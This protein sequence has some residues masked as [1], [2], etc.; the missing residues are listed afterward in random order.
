MI[1][2]MWVFISIYLSFLSITVDDSPVTV[3]PELWVVSAT[4]SS[5]PAATVWCAGCCATVS[6]VWAAAG[7][8]AS[9]ASG[10]AAAA[11]ATARS[12]AGWSAAPFA[13][14]S[15]AARPGSAA[16]ASAGWSA[17]SAAALSAVGRS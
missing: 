14:R 13:G 17:T 15:A 16:A 3:S 10:R 4:A 7:R 9:A 12:G 11:A 6:S 1:T 2:C 5:A 8:S